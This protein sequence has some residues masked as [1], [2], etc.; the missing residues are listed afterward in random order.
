[1]TRF[2]LILALGLAAC[3]SPETPPTET[4]AASPTTGAA[5]PAA[6]AALTVSD[7]YAPAAPRGGTSALFFTI[8]GGPTPDTLASVAFDGAAKTN[9]HET[10]IEADGLR[11][12]QPVAGIPVPAGAT[13][14]LAPGG[15]HAMLVELARPLAAGDTLSA[16]A[17]FTSGTTLPLR[18]I[19]RSIDDLPAPTP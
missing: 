17:T 19:V 18:A 14:A 2:S 15:Y 13:V 3:T 8:A 4:G 16:T 7:A 11:R 10:V 9:V 1:M 5:A 12:M 6:P